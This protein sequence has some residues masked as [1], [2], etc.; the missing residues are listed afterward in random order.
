MKEKPRRPWVAVLLNVLAVGLGHIYAG[1]AKRGIILFFAI[2]LSLFVMVLVY[3]KP[4]PSGLNLV[5][6]LLL[7]LALFLWSYIDAA[8][9]ARRH[10][11]DYTLKPYNKWY[12]YLLI[13]LFVHMVVNPLLSVGVRNC[14]V[15]AYRIPSSSMSPTVLSDDYILVNKLLYH[16]NAPARGEIIV[17]HDP[18]AGE[19][20][21]LKRIVGLPGETIQMRDRVITVDGAPI[22]DEPYAHYD[23]PGQG[24]GTDDFGPFR[25]PEG[26]YFTLGD[27]RLNS[28]DSRAHGPVPF[29][30]IR[31]KA[32]QIYW[33]WESTAE[34][35]WGRIG[36]M[37]E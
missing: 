13:I 37:L 23:E 4:L 27:N 5:V 32:Y 7:F 16:W 10:R 9:M 28:S 14:F 1:E 31:G 34:V 8:V 6:P 19:R 30:L 2:W 29:D 17:Y 15:Q 18:V 35:R 11:R 20:D 3:L 25:I 26:A 24:G 36:T 33:S 22:G 12:L 21:Y